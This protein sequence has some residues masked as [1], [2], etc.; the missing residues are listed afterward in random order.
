MGPH[1]ATV[2]GLLLLEAEVAVDAVVDPLQGAA[3]VVAALP[4]RAAVRGGD[5]DAPVVLVEL[6]AHDAPVLARI[7]PAGLVAFGLALALQAVGGGRAAV[8][9]GVAIGLEALEGQIALGGNFSSQMRQVSCG[10]FGLGDELSKAES[11][12]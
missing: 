3:A 10:K 5:E 7:H 2:A 8:L 9:E 6:D 4:A 1:G 12:L 11:S